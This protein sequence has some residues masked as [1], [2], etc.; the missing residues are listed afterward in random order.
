LHKLEF[1]IGDLSS[2]T[3]IGAVT[4]NMWTSGIAPVT[5]LPR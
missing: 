4:I 3:A 5:S 1:I 2:I